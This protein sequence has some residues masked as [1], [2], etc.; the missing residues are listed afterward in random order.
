MATEI[1]DV[2]NNEKR[3]TI[4]TV[5]SEMAVYHLECILYWCTDE[6]IFDSL[7]RDLLQMLK[8]YVQANPNVFLSF[9]KPTEMIDRVS[10]IL[11]L[12][13]QLKEVVEME[14]PWKWGED[15]KGW[16]KPQD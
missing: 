9:R 1:K 12:V 10:M 14:K 4:Q 16:I 6:F 5:L 15:S 8:I 3:N 11:Q 7:S 2:R 13:E